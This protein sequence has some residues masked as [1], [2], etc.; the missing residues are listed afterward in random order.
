MIIIIL[1]ILLNFLFRCYSVFGYLPQ[2][3]LGMNFKEFV[4]E[5]DRNKLT[6]IWNRSKKKEHSFN[7]DSRILFL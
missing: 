6:E 3:L 7:F 5:D 2:D 1:V 4:H